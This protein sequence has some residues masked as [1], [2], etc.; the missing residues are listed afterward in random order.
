MSTHVNDGLATVG[1]LGCEEGEMALGAVGGAV[2]LKE[3]L[4]NNAHLT[5]GTCEVLWMP[6]PTQCSD[7]LKVKQNNNATDLD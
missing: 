7:H 2:V 1:A 5:T 6:H 3:V 4:V